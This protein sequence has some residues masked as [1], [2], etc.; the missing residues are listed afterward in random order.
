MHVWRCKSEHWTWQ[1]HDCKDHSKDA[2]YCMIHSLKIYWSSKCHY[3]VVVE[4]K[5]TYLRLKMSIWDGNN[6]SF[7]RM[8]FQPLIRYL[9]CATLQHKYGRNINTDVY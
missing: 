6:Y 7:W 9:T 5:F 8:H 3:G 1:L 2:T 4:S